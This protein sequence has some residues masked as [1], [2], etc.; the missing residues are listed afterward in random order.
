M[1][2]DKLLRNIRNDFGFTV[3][4]C[5]QMVIVMKDWVDKHSEIYFH[6]SKNA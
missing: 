2:L 3:P 6:Y 1:K 4:S 5:E